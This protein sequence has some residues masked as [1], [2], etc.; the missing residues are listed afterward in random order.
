VANIQ[1]YI[2]SAPVVGATLPA[3]LIKKV[4]PTYPQIAAIAR[5]KG[6]VELSA[7][8]NKDGKIGKITVTSG[9]P[10]LRDAAISAVKQWVYKPAT[11]NGEPV[12]STVA[13]EINFAGR[14]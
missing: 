14:E 13:V 3:Q 4:P 10:M 7:T 1:P 6:K 12:E 9:N 11:R 5:T 8:V 2:P